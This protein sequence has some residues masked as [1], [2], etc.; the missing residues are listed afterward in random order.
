M[1]VRTAVAENLLQFHEVPLRVQTSAA[2]KTPDSRAG[3]VLKG[4]CLPAGCGLGDC[5][6]DGFYSLHHGVQMIL[7]SAQTSSFCCFEVPKHV[8]VSVWMLQ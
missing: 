1:N 6:K 2:E 4:G 7:K 5:G 8:N 3:D